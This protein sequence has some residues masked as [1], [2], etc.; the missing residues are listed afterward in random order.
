MYKNYKHGEVAKVSVCV[1]YVLCTQ[2]TCFAN[3]FFTRI[4]CGQYKDRNRIICLA[5]P[6]L[7]REFF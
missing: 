2:N 3:K 1:F 5:M 4:K 6:R 7:V